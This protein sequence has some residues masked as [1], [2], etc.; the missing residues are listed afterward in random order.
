[1]AER[2]QIAQFAQETPEPEAQPGRRQ[3]ICEAAVELFAERGY[4][5]SSLPALA[6]KAGVSPG[7][8]YRYFASKEALANELFQQW[9]A[10][11]MDLLFSDYD[12]QREAREQHHIWWH[13]A[14]DFARNHPS[15]FTFLVSHHHGPYLDEANRNAD[16][17]CFDIVNDYFTRNAEAGITKPLPPV[18]L[19]E[20]MKGLLFELMRSELRG[21]ITLTPE[22]IEQTEMCCWD[23]VRL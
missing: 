7:L 1:M 2:P 22:L 9:H 18:V 6:A 3:A 5:G 15:A 19:M 13:R 17:V 4:Y 11:L 16:Q 10:R 20:M 12:P 8:I 14:A 21:L 23:A